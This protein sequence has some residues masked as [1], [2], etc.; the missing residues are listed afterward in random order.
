MQ[1]NRIIR[2]REAQSGP[3]AGA[4]TKNTLSHTVASLGIRPPRYASGGL[5]DGFSY[6]APAVSPPLISAE[7]AFGGV[8]RV[9]VR[10]AFAEAEACVSAEAER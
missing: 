4:G 7:A 2:P 6:P 9:W 3:T 8:A 10:R 5:N 1:E